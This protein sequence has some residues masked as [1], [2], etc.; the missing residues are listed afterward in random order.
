M[1]YNFKTPMSKSRSAK[2]V[3]LLAASLLLLG[4]IGQLCASSPDAWSDFSKDV[5]EKMD[6][7]VKQKFGNY[8]LVVDPVGTESYGVALAIGTSVKG[9]QPLTVIGIYNKR[10]KKLELMEMP[11]MKLEG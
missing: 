11:G 9:N 2:F 4:S 8:A 5:R 6:K 1:S 10:T 7:A 3:G